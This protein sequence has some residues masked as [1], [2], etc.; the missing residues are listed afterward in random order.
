M[1]LSVMLLGSTNGVL[2]VTGSAVP[3][4]GYYGIS[5]TFHTISIEVSNF[6]GRVKLQG[7]I[8]NC[9]Q[10][11]DWFDL[12]IFNGNVWQEYPINPLAPSA[13]PNSAG[14]SG[15]NYLNFNVNLIF[16]RCQIDRTYLPNYDPTNTDQ[17]Y[18]NS[19]GIVSKIL[20]AR[21]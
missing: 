4:N 19:F 13:A 3:V 9:P 11:S 14:D 18:I 6:I 16:V 10:E 1:P 17:D 2:N 12:P 5:N 21:Q 8:S 20:L 15:T 7:T